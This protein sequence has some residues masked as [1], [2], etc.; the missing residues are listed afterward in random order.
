MKAFHDKGR[1]RTLME[2]FPV[3]IVLN[4]KVGLIGAAIFA[5]QF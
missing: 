2:N 5:A 4:A 1:M 3:Y